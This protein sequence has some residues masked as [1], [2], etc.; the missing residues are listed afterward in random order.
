M[1]LDG[2]N[3]EVM[4]RNTLYVTPEVGDAVKLRLIDVSEAAVAVRLEGGCGGGGLTVKVTFA[5]CDKLPLVPVIVSVDA[6]SG[7]ELAVATLSVD[8]PEPLI[9]A[10][11]KLAV[12]PEGKPLALKATVPLN[13]FCAAMLTV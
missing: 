11:L 10:G 12:A 3:P 13:P 6:P 1:L 7:V 5:V 8:E 4:L 2:V 9:E